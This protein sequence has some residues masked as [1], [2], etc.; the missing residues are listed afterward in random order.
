[1]HTRLDDRGGPD[2]RHKECDANTKK[3]V[4]EQKG[5]AD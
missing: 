5:V 2:A 4:R 1:M 3:V